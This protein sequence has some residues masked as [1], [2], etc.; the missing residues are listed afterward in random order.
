LPAGLGQ[1][2]WHQSCGTAPGSLPGVRRLRPEE[3]KRS[4]W[5]SGAVAWLAAV[6]ILPA[7]RFAAPRATSRGSRGG[8]L[9]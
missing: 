1:A 9:M 4:V 3:Q 7:L 5:R 6:L 2:S 8:S